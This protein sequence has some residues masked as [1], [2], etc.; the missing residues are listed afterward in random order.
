MHTFDGLIDDVLFYNRAI[1][2]EEIKSLVSVARERLGGLR[3]FGQV[4]GRNQL[5]SSSASRNQTVDNKNL[6]SNNSIHTVRDMTSRNVSE[7]RERLQEVNS[8]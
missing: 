1:G 5:C 3:P 2:P 6:F 8:E 7:T 4:Y